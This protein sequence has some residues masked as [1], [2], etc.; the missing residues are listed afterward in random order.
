MQLNSI[1]LKI[2]MC[3]LQPHWAPSYS[4]SPS[5][6]W[7]SFLLPW[8]WGLGQYVLAKACLDLLL[9][10]GINLSKYPTVAVRGLSVGFVALAI[11]AQISMPKS[12]PALSQIGQAV[13]VRTTTTR[14]PASPKV[15][16]P[17]P[18]DYGM[19]KAAEARLS[20]MVM[21]IYQFEHSV[22]M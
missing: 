1:G 20:P 5:T 16:T 18:L 19:A 9:N 14:P 11:M 2:T 22:K 13:L 15:P 17:P 12:K 10:K 6:C 7:D 21:A 4:R 8:I 3:L